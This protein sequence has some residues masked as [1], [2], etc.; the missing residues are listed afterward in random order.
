MLL[1]LERLPVN[2]SAFLTPSLLL[3]H[4]TTNIVQCTC[5][6]FSDCI[7][8]LF[9]SLSLSLSLSL[10]HSLGVDGADVDHEEN[11]HDFREN[12]VFGENESEFSCMS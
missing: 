12:G 11:C 4:I 2:I 9:I 5:T 3:P 7:I 8:N 6:L 1:A 10:T